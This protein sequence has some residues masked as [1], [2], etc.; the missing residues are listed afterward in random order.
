MKFTRYRIHFVLA[1]LLSGL[2]SA[3][4]DASE[5]PP[6]AVNA[7]LGDESFVQRFGRVPSPK[8]QYASRI[9]THLRFV[10]SALQRGGEGRTVEVQRRRNRALRALEAYIQ[11]GE[12][13][14]RTGDAYVGTRPRF[15]DDRGVHCAVGYMLLSTGYGDLARAIDHDYEYAYL[16]EM[17]SSA[18]KT[19]AEEYGFSLLELASIQPSY[20]PPP[21][22][23]MVESQVRRRADD[24]ALACAHRFTFVPRV[25]IRARGGRDGRVRLTASPRSAFGR[26]LVDEL[27]RSTHLGGGAWDTQPRRFR[28]VIDLELKSPQYQLRQRLAETHFSNSRC[29]MRPGLI[30]RRVRVD[31]EVAEA[32]LHASVRTSP[33]NVESEACFVEFVEQR[34]RAFAAGHVRAN[35]HVARILRSDPMPWRLR[36]TLE[37]RARAAVT[38]C[39]AH[40]ISTSRVRV[41]ARAEAGEETFAVDV[42]D[43]TQGFRECV[44]EVLVES[45]TRAFSTRRERGDGT[46]ERYFRANTSLSATYHVPVETPEARRQRLEA[47]E[48]EME[49]EQFRSSVD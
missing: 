37:H 43:G 15:I 32:G 45:L 39:H 40:G 19:W 13:P 31:L 34:F 8:D 36:Q 41:R 38:A 47:L 33:R 11:R 18:L 16:L 3:N 28:T 49:E 10:H 1:L 26:C 22:A 9:A 25:T 24:A 30:P 21:D 35:A 20:A 14:R 17:E 23:E 44:R 4:A 48:R 27:R 29:A 46:S 5:G 42:R 12:F 6:H 7:V 2:V